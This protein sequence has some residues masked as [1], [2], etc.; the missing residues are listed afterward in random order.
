MIALMRDAMGVGLAATQLG[1]MQRLFVFAAGPDATPTAVANPEI[2]WL[3]EEAATAE[4]GCLSLPGIAVDVERPLYARVR[5]QDTRGRAADARVGGP[6]GPRAPARD[7]SS[8]RGP[9]ARPHRARA[10]QGGAAGAARGRELRAADRRGPE[11]AIAERDGELRLTRWPSAPSTSAPPSFAA[12]VLRVLAVSPYRPQLVVTPPDRRQ[13]RGRK[14]SPPPAAVVAAR[15]RHRPAAGR[16]RQ[17]AG[18]AGAD[19][20]R[21]A[22]RRRRLRLRPDHPRAAALRARRCSTSTRRCC[23]AGAGRR[24]SSGRS[25]PAT[26]RPG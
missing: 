20:R 13:G 7:R 25:W 4:E 11:D 26:P 19:R 21:G 3:S 23:P 22:R 15:R 5:G 1:V 12:T 14:L 2:E 9:D 6:R 16:G 17:R 8:R 24:R 18:V 10:A